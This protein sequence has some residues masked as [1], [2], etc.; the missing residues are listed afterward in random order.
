MKYGILSVFL[1]FFVSACSNEMA[2]PGGAL[3]DMY[4][5]GYSGPLGYFVEDK[6]ERLNKEGVVLF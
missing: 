1:C 3:P 5:Y 6:A 2:V 4:R